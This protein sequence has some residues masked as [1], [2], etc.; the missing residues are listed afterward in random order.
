MSALDTKTDQNI[1]IITW[2]DIG[3]SIHLVD[4]NLFVAIYIALKII[5]FNLLHTEGK[6]NLCNI[7]HV[8]CRILKMVNI[9]TFDFLNPPAL[10]YLGL[11]ESARSAKF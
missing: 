8:I 2:V 11:N 6:Q 3:R 4:S 1:S 10:L 7:R 5:T 9:Q